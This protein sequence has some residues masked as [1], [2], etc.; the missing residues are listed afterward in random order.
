MVPGAFMVLAEFPLNA[1][2]KLDRKALPAPV[3][4]TKAFRA[5][6]TV[7]EQT[8]AQVFGEVLGSEKI[9]ADDDFFALGGNSLIATQ[10]VSRVSA[11]VDARVPVRTLFEASTVEEF[12]R[13][14]ETHAGSG[15]VAPLVPQPRPERVP[16]SF[17][18]QRMWFLNR[19]DPE[20][21]VNN[22]PVAIRLTGALDV[23]ALSH[24]VGDVV[25]RHEILRTYYPDIDGVGVQ[26]VVPTAE[27]G[28]D[29]VAEPVDE[30][31]VFTTVAGYVTGGFDVAVAPPVRVRLL[32][33]SETEHVLVVVVH[34]IAADGFSMGPLARDVMIAYAAR[35]AGEAPSWQP[36]EVQYAD[37]A[38]WQ[39]QVLG[40]EEDPESV[41]ARQV[42]Y[43]TE[44]LAGAPDVL[45]LPADRPRP[46]VAS[47][48]GATHHFVLG[49]DVVSGIDSLAASLGLT[50]FM[51]VHSALA[52]LLAR[53][54]GTDDIAIGTPVAGR[55]ERALDDLIGMFVNTLVL[56]TQVDSSESFRDL[57]VRVREVDL[58]AFGHADVPFE[59]LVEVLD[60]V[61]S[62]AWNPLFQVMLTMQ[63]MAPTQFE[64][65]GLSLS[66][67]DAD[68]SLAKF[69]L[70]VTLAEQFDDR[71]ESAGMAVVLTYATDL[72]DEATMVGFAER[73]VRVLSGGVADPSMPVGDVDLFLADEREQL[74]T[75]GRGDVASTSE[76][77]TDLIAAQME[78]TPDTA[79]VSVVGDE[80]TYAQ[81]G[82]RVG[83]LAR[84]LISAGVGPRCGS[85]WRWI[86]R[87]TWCSQSM[88]YSRRVAPMCRSTRSNRT[89]G[90]STC[91]S[92][93]IL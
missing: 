3:F 25:T 20:S 51:V 7:T 33:M 76:V 13:A 63:N 84:Y 69:D 41:I 79:A 9:G 56:R 50:R 37:Y 38:L 40:S 1:S 39:R 14:I 26:I 42:A 90:S 75:F 55:G 87:S 2:G 89:T 15:G 23:G 85:R 36:L 44:Q 70:Q 16:L 49:S 60:P 22:I 88:Q 43:W 46:A 35:S 24:A 34:H 73:F 18:Q 29:L 47:N 27:A 53:L 77:L 62:T 54:S 52:V 30:R 81:F 31:D 72:F 80:L 45:G 93:P 57:L 65:P 86:A 82:D 32:R 64:L 48:L 71:G 66:A 74:L 10:V 19:F 6:A 83:R 67:V 59:R 5:P 58:G 61:R 91:S 17:A 78:R 68:V 8:V 12:A 28:V 92:P 4:E 11:V 21:A